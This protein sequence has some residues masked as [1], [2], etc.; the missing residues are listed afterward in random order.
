MPV[1]RCMQPLRYLHFRHGNFSRRQS[2]QNNPSNACNTALVNTGIC[3]SPRSHLKTVA[4]D[5]LHDTH[6]GAVRH[7]GHSTR[8]LWSTSSL[9]QLWPWC[10]KARALSPLA[11]RSL[12]RHLSR[13]VC[14]VALLMGALLSEARVSGSLSA[15]HAD[16]RSKPDTARRL[17]R[18]QT[19]PLLLDKSACQQQLVHPCI[20]PPL[21]RHQC[22]A[23]L[24]CRR[25]QPGQL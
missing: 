21:R 7:A 19:R 25:N 20:A 15:F 23:A 2:L 17:K 6:C 22:V 12:V 24:S 11:A 18:L 4:L 5:T 16:D 10:G 13:T 1:L 8:I 14:C 3:M 9:G